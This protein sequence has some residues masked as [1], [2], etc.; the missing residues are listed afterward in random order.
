MGM[1]GMNAVPAREVSKSAGTK[2]SKVNVSKTSASEG[3]AASTG[4]AAPTTGSGIAG[5]G[6]GHATVVR[7]Q[8]G[9]AA[10][11]LGVNSAPRG[12]QS[13]LMNGKI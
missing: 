2:S 10:P 13:G 12:F 1:Q 8:A 11:T 9:A 7:D 6:S 4:K 5:F 3:S